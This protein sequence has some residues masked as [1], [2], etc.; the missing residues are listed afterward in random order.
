M[1]HNDEGAESPTEVT[2]DAAREALRQYWRD[3]LIEFEEIVY[4]VFHER[5]YSK[6]TALQVYMID[7]LDDAVMVAVSSIKESK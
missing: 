3:R 4:P 2:Q 1:P 6:N 7:E 5:G